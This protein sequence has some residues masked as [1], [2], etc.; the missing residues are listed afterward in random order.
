MK[1]QSRQLLR[2]CVW[3]ELRILTKVSECSSSVSKQAAQLGHRL[4]ATDFDVLIVSKDEHD[5]GLV[6]KRRL[7]RARWW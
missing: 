5:V 3:G 7:R 6:P 2:G 1:Q 4:E